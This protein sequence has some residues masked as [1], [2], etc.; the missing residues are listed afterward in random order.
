VNSRLDALQACI[1]RVKLRYLEQWTEGRRK[2]AAR[3]RELFS[4]YA[5]QSFVLLPQETPEVYHVYNQYVVR[6]QRRDELQEHLR[7]SGIP[8]EIYYPNPLHL[9]P[10][11]AGL[12]YKEGSF[13]ESESA[14]REVLAL[15][16][17]PELT[18]HQQ[19]AVVTAIADFYQAPKVR[20]A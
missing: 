17:Y 2:N 18:A 5:L 9:Q 13:P 6:V 8:T 10:A 20:G 14:C 4:D 1:L 19:R 11:F 15:P 7:H 12:G 3:Y 16:V